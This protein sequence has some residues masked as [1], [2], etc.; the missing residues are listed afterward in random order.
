MAKYINYRSYNDKA[1]A[2]ELC[3]LLTEHNIPF[4]WES[5]EGL[6]DASFTN[7]DIL[8]IY[9][10]KIRQEDFE[11]ADEILMSLAKE[12]KEE[13]VEDY[14]L[15]SF[16]NEE[17]LDVLKKPDDW[18][19]YDRYWADKILAKRGI[20]VN[21]EELNKAKNERLAELK[22][23]WTLDKLWIICAIALWV[24][25]FYFI[26]FYWSIAVMFIGGYISLS[27]KTMPD[28][29]RVKAFSK[30]D[31][32]IGKIVLIAGIA[33]TLFIFLQYFGV[34]DFGWPL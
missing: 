33:L 8:N 9:Y 23:P 7:N 6:F 22:K 25:S 32:L 4:D 15:Y 11:K 10:I 29:E 5:T 26:T 3:Q 13:P 2:N 24:Y 30:G 20:Q 27:K 19:E 18:N 21:P 17:L 1:L 14:Y 31:R 34:I 28:G 12:E 16:S